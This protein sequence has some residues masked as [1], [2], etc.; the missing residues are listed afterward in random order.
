[1]DEDSSQETENMAIVLEKKKKKRFPSGP[2]GHNYNGDEKLLSSVSTYMQSALGATRWFTRTTNKTP[3][4]TRSVERD[5][6]AT[7]HT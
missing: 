4:P 1:M 7:H 5:P 6:S 3:H 2:V